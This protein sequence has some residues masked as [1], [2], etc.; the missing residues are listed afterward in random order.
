MELVVLGVLVSPTVTAMSSVE[1][2]ESLPT[3]W[4]SCSFVVPG[5]A[6][7]RSILQAEMLFVVTWGAVV[8]ETPWWSE[9]RLGGEESQRFCEPGEG[10]GKRCEELIDAFWESVSKMSRAA[11]GEGNRG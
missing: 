10:Q 11:N 3:E 8:E 9:L 7:Q 1:A 6:A 2:F 4:R 5:L